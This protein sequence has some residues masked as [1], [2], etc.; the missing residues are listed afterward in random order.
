MELL[1]DTADG[2]FV[3]G[4]GGFR[5]LQLRFADV[6]FLTRDRFELDEFPTAC[7][8]PSLD[9]EVR[10]GLSQDRPGAEI[11]TDQLAQLDV[12]VGS[13]WLP[14]GHTLA[15]AHPDA[16]DEAA[17]ERPDVRDARVLRGHGAGD[18]DRGGKRSRLDLGDRQASVLHGIDWQFH[19]APR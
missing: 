8:D 14:R 3:A 11:L 18:V 10:F 9:L 1:L 19:D 2:G 6:E 13:Q 4:H 12:V 5:R 7:H 16:L 15:E 17:R